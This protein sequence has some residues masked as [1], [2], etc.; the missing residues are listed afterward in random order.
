MKN[1]IRFIVSA[2][3]VF[4][5]FFNNLPSVKACG[6]F[7][8][9]PLF[10]L[11]KHADYPLPEF[12]NGK[13]GIVPTSFGRMSLFVFYRYLNNSSLTKAEQ[14]QVVATMENRIGT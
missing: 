6:P 9:I 10:S 1:S 3:L 8:L 12:T 2:A 14:K 13:T 11:N 7:T 4:V 5:F